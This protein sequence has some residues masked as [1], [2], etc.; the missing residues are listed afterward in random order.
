M[1]LIKAV[2]ASSAV[3][4]TILS[5]A[6]TPVA[7]LA[8]PAHG[9]SARHAHAHPAPGVSP[10][11]GGI[12]KR[13]RNLHKQRKR[14]LAQN[15]P[16][17]GATS[18]S[19]ASSSTPTDTGNNNGGSTGNTGSTGGN[20]GGG[21]QVSSWVCSNT[22]TKIAIAMEWMLA[23]NLAAFRGNA[24]GVYNWAAYPP[25]PNQLG[26]L[27]Y[28]PMLARGDWN[29]V[30]EFQNNVLNS[31][32]HYNW[33]L[34][35]NEVNQRGQAAG[36]GD[37][38]DIGW[39]AQLW[40]DNLLPLRNRGTG[41]VSPSTTNTDGGLDW[42]QNWMNTLGGNEQPD[43][44]ATHWYGTSPD[45]LRNWL[46]KVH[47]RFGKPIWLTEFACNDFS[48]N[49]CPMDVFAF[50]AAAKAIVNSLDYVVVA[51]PFG[52]VNTLSGVN[53]ASRLIYD[54]GYP[55]DLAKMWLSY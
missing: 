49:S 43:A 16:N 11:H 53:Y 40:R 4:F 47:N 35:F 50:A 13:K 44:I 20:T 39:A 3:A 15:N 52:F 54:G 8:A 31:G 7:A 27:Q 38:M 21:S 26:N 48:T 25:D 41:L 37:Y 36:D 42:L 46:E 51:A 9:L 14:C 22:N 6:V 12:I 10:N 17:T 1:T 2:V 34:G 32:T 5:Q 55:N 19:S 30:N 24:C 28:W 29:N 23:D 45:D 33:V 18:S